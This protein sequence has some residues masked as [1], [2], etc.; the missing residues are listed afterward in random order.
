MSASMVHEHDF[1]LPTN[2]LKNHYTL[3]RFQKDETFDR[4]A[5]DHKD[6]IERMGK[7]DRYNF[8]AW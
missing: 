5:K 8:G 6:C 7:D 4:M 2:D 3:L 1:K